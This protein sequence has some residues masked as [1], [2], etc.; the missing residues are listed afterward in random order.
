MRKSTGEVLER[1]NSRI[2]TDS[3]VVEKGSVIEFEIMIILLEFRFHNVN[4]DFSGCR[5]RRVIRRS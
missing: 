4:L 5:G 3:E 1:W 2:E